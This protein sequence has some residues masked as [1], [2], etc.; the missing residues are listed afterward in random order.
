[1]G[2]PFKFNVQYEDAA[3]RFALRLLAF[4]SLFGQAGI[5]GTF[6]LPVAMAVG[7]GFVL[8]EKYI[9]LRAFGTGVV[10]SLLFFYAS[11]FTSIHL[12]M[13][14]RA[15]RNPSKRAE[16]TLSDGHISLKSDCGETSLPWRIFKGI[17]SLKNMWVFVSDEGQFLDGEQYLILPLKTVPKDALDFITSKVRLV[18]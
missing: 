12:Q 6:V 3:I 4:R 17:L 8:G 18:W 7:L 2:A 11:F 9:G 10:G 14:R 16:V 1:M 15:R 5:I 13:R